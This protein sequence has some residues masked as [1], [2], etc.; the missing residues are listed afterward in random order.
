MINNLKAYL[1]YFP[2]ACYSHDFA[3]FSC[4]F[5]RKHS[6]IST[7]KKFKLLTKNFFNFC[8]EIIKPYGILHEHRR[9]IISLM[10]TVTKSFSDNID[11]TLALE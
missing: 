8:I 5:A 3:K 11:V 10:A 1:F 4:V 6:S 2:Y 7:L 9:L